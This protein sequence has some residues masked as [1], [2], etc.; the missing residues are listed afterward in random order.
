MADKAPWMR[1]WIWQKRNRNIAK[2]TEDWKLGGQ[3]GKKKQRRHSREGKN[4]KTGRKGLQKIV[5][6]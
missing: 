2:G 6:G 4:G 5:K 1:V 3:R